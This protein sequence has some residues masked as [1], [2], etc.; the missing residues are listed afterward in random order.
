MRRT[1]YPIGR[2]SLEILSVVSWISASNG[3]HVRR[4]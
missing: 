3:L 4:R 1:P 2:K